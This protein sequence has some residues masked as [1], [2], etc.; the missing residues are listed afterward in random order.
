MRLAKCKAFG[1]TAMAAIWRGSSVPTVQ[2]RHSCAATILDGRLW[3]TPTAS[4]CVEGAP[5]QPQ[6]VQR[7]GPNPTSSAALDVS[8]I[9]RR[10]R[11]LRANVSTSAFETRH[12]LLVPSVWRDGHG[13]C[14]VRKRRANSSTAPLVCANSSRRALVAR[15]RPPFA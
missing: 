5:G 14:V 15:Q 7:P 13:S 6:R 1:A 4:V 8:L 9:V 10:C 12:A 3:Y 2:W 11:S